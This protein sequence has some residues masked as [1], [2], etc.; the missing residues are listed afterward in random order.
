MVRKAAYIVVTM[1]FRD[2]AGN[3]FCACQVNEVEGVRGEESSIYS[4][5]SDF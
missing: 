5:D 3:S 1:I 4:S 2:I